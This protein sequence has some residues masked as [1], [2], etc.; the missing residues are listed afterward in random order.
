MTSHGTLSSGAVDVPIYWLI[1][2][3]HQLIFLTAVGDVY[4]VHMEECLDIVEGAGA[5]GYRKL[6]DG[7][8]ANIRMAEDELLAIGV[9]LRSLHVRAVGALAIV[10]RQDQLPPLRR[11][12]GILAA[13]DR[14]LR[15]FE[16][17]SK[18]ENWI[19]S[20]PGH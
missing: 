3:R 7:V 15:L 14:P 5:V 11:L 12:L 18:A 9:R 2:S 6:F 10:L 1:D 8:H 20:L 4:R 16:T 13:A 17:R 19:R